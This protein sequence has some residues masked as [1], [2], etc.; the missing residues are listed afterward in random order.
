MKL[1]NDRPPPE[2]VL[3]SLIGSLKGGRVFIDR[4]NAGYSTLFESHS[5]IFN[6]QPKRRL[7][8]I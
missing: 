3:C 6:I 4:C 5:K 1:E 7:L 8:G 2:K